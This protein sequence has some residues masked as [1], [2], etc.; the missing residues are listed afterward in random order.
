MPV[1]GTHLELRIRTMTQRASAKG[2]GAMLVSDQHPT[3]NVERY[4]QLITAEQH[5]GQANV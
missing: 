1:F 2:H 4:G 5:V 3:V